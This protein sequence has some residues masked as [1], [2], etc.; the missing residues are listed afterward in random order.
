MLTDIKCKSAKPEDKQYKLFDERG[1]Y[2]LIH[3]NGSK[4][5]RMR[6][7]YAGKDKTLSFGVYPEVSL[8]EARDKRDDAREIIRD[9]I[10]PGKKL[11]RQAKNSFGTVAL[12]WWEK[13]RMRWKEEHA[14]SVIKSLQTDVFPYLG[15]SDVNDIDVPKLLMVLRK[16][17]SRNALDFLSRVHQRCEAVFSYAIVTGRCERNPAVDLKGALATRK[18][19]QYLRM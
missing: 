9:G 7:R 1:L 2:L 10:D 16:I 12:E 11:K 17:K 8:K 13:Q 18:V 5:W 15:D 14:N 4:Y 6:Y 3:S 19:K